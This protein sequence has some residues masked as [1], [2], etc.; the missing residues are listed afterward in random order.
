[1]SFFSQI[2]DKLTS[3][4]Q[5]TATKAK[6]FAEATKLNGRVNDLEKQISQLYEE[7]GKA[8]FENHKEDA[9]AEEREKIEKICTIQ[10]EIADCKEQIKDL[11]GVENC[12]SCGAEVVPGAA[13][14]NVCGAKMEQP[15]VVQKAE[16]EKEQKVCPQCQAK[17]DED[18]SFC[19]SCG[20]KLS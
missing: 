8:Y 17:I 3:V 19:T 10:Q 4:G 12:P 9:G 2:G 6:N 5:E 11:K 14:C 13:F 18:A 1:M 15:E 20:A 16:P 7:I